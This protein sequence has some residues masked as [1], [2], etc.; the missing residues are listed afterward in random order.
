MEPPDQ[1]HEKEAMPK[2]GAVEVL[3]DGERGLRRWDPLEL[4]EDVRDE[5][6]RLWNEPLPAWPGARV[7]RER[8]L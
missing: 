7:V 5:M 6:W 4:L 1:S 8:S 2:K 3:G